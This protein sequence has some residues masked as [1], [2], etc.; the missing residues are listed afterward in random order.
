MS[1]S[2]T[3]PTR[4]PTWRRR[5]QTKSVRQGQ[6]FTVANIATTHRSSSVMATTQNGSVTSMCR[7]KTGI[8]FRTLECVSSRPICSPDFCSA[9][10][11]AYVQWHPKN[12]VCATL[13]RVGR[14]EHCSTIRDARLCTRQI[15]CVEDDGQ[16][17]AKPSLHHVRNQLVLSSVPTHAPPPS[18]TCF[19]LF[20]EMLS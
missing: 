12:L 8:E 17:N 7:Q 5:V 15:R 18:H 10:R 9:S 6:N 3:S 13:Q 4:G 20:G 16:H 2:G 14:N 11:R 1:E 19:S